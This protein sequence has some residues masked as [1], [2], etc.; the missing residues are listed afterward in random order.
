MT[1]IDQLRTDITALAPDIAAWRHTLHSCPEIGFEERKTA[2]FVADLLTSFGIEVDRGLAGTGLVGTL[3]AGS[4]S[5]SIGLR[6]ELDALPITEETGLA[7][8]SKN[9]GLMHACGHDGHMAMLLGAA[10]YLA[11]TRR[12][13]GTVRF[14]FQP[15]EENLAGG[16][17]MVRDG[18]FERF[19]VDAIYAMH[20]LPTMPVGEFAVQDGPTM[21]S[22][23]M[24]ELTLRGRGGHAA[25]PHMA[26]DPGIVVG[27]I[28][29]GV[30]SIV[31]RS[32]AP[33]DA[34]VVSITKIR[35]GSTLNV[36]P[37]EALLGGTLRAHKPEVRDRIE[38]RLRAIVA[39]L[40]AAHGL[41]HEF[42]FLTRYPPTINHHDQAVRALMAAEALVG[43]DKVTRDLPP[44]MG[45][46]DF[47]FML[48]V[49]PGCYI[50]IGNGPNCAPLHTPDYDFADPALIHGASYWGVLVEQELPQA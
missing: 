25:H 30:Q 5:R 2:D 17:V 48:N 33:I 43:A 9:A 42:R 20:N 39:G 7:Y 14:V 13:D 46:E 21:A 11:R 1:A 49:N 47:G 24:W 8:A 34:A 29:Q 41:E 3:K 19:P 31:S 18:L 15:A 35:M 37:E 36:I 28:L 6:A 4:S 23:D 27:A 12:F 16:D 38:E 32:V 10:A 45:A 26:R 40:C 22:A 50:R 44:S